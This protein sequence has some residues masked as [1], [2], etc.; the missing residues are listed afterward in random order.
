LPIFSNAYSKNFTPSVQD[1]GVKQPESLQL[2]S[3]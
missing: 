3:C 1:I 2:D